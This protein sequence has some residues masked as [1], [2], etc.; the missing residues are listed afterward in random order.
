MTDHTLS[1]SSITIRVPVALEQKRKNRSSLASEVVLSIDGLSCTVWDHVT[2]TDCGETYR[3]DP[4]SNLGKILDEIL[5][6]R[7]LVDIP[8]FAAVFKAVSEQYALNRGNPSGEFIRPTV[9]AMEAALAESQGS[10][11]YFAGAGSR[12]KIGWSRKVGSRIAQL[13]TGNSDPI[14]LLGVIPGGRAK[15]RQL[16]EQFAHARLSGEW[17]DATPDLMAFIEQ[18]AA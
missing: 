18:T 7:K 12:I 11:V 8:H 17:F 4:N 9:D 14:R 13:Q 10:S 16:H 3:F 5:G 1:I 15:E 6:P 2:F